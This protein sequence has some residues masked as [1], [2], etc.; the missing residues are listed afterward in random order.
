MAVESHPQFGSARKLQFNLD[1]ITRPISAIALAA[2]AIAS[3][4][5]GAPYFTIVVGLLAL[6]GAREWHRMVESGAFAW[7][8]VITVVA[9]AGGLVALSVQPSSPLSF[10]VLALGALFTYGLVRLRHGHALWHAA[11]IPYVGIPALCLVALRSVTP[12]GA[13]LIVGLFLIIWSTDTGA[14]ITGNLI[15]GPKLTPVLS[16]NKTWSGTLGGIV[17][18]GIV[19]AIYVGLLGGSV[20]RAAIY[21]LLVAVAAHSGDLFESWV[22]RTFRFKDSGGLIP[23]HGGVLDRIDSTLAA[24]LAVAAAVFGFGLDP[25]FGAHL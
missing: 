25:L 2:I 1:W 4:A 21:A 17:V 24:A 20:W 16:P 14:L 18:A 15:G 10:V 5:A 22:K 6:A 9:V 8:F 3:I 11:A 13:W 23:G 7:E 12:H 19:E